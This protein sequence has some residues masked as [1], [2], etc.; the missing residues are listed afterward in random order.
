MLERISQV[1]GRLPLSRKL[2]LMV[3]LLAVPVLVLGAMFLRAQNVQ[4]EAQRRQLEGVRFLKPLV[5]LELK[6]AEHRLA[7]VLALSGA[8]GSG[9]VR[10]A[11]LEVDSALKVALDAQASTGDQFGT[12][13]LLKEVAESWN[14]NVKLNWNTGSASLTSDM[15]TLLVAQVADAVRMVGRSVSPEAARQA[16]TGHLDRSLPF[17]LPAGIESLA[18]LGAFGLALG[19]SGAPTQEQW[20]QIV[21][22]AQEARNAVDGLRAELV[23]ADKA[24]AGTDGPARLAARQAVTSADA[25]LESV[26]DATARR[27]SVNIEPAVF[28]AQADEAI[29]N[30][31][32]LYTRLVETFEGELSDSLAGLEAARNFELVG[33]VVLV[34]LALGLGYVIADTIRRQV[35]SMSSVFARIR[36]GDLQARAE[37]VAE[38][39]FGTFA[40]SL[41]QVLDNSIALVQSREERDRIQAGIRKLLREMEGVAQGDLTQEAESSEG[42]TGDIAKSFN[43]MLVELR[44]LINRVQ[45]STSAVNAA[46]SIAEEVTAKLASGSQKQ[47][48][49]IVEASSAVNQMTESVQQVTAQAAT[50][51]HIAQAAL[52]NAQQGAVSAQLTI[53][54]MGEVRRQVQGM[55]TL[56][57][58]LAESSSQ[59]GDIT[60][61]I[62]DV[63]KRTSILALNASIQAAVAGD[64]GKGFGV[65][66]EQVEE[67]A[68]RSSEAVRRV[69]ALTKSIQASTHRVTEAL[70]GA[71]RQVASGE[72]LAAEASERLA[73]IQEV[74]TQLAGVVE[75]ILSACRQQGAS[76]EFIASSMGEISR[77]TK[78]TTAGVES[79]TGSIHQLAGLVEQLRGSVSRFRLPARSGG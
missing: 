56:V 38:D 33:I 21:V 71:T 35:A 51:A 50:A 42:L 72:T 9:P 43:L 23:R 3:A 28:R 19:K 48:A 76:S 18:Q 26:Q 69:A 65:V 74:A 15:H 45:E 32:T 7:A 11:N 75:S 5:A 41:N 30:F 31:R 17:V 64:S 44:G 68:A 13:G 2:G 22:L 79:A 37:V 49:Q 73:E 61:L 10:Q 62:A 1:I 25:F 77:V 78:Y 58:E 52:R 66:A 53:D 12:G 59:I 67:L 14:T 46:A 39:E 34:G 27:D 70:E 6:L 63:S 47:S 20:D 54:G 16:R 55:G 57:R 8:G 36:K 29:T 24:S 4:L 60:Q 40:A